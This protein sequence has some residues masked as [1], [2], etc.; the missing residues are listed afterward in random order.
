MILF[1]NITCLFT[2]SAIIAPCTNKY[3]VILDTTSEINKIIP[4]IKA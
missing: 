4:N 1:Y 3:V 2:G